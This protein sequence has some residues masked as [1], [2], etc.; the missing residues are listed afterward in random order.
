[1]TLFMKHIYDYL[2]E[3]AARNPQKTAISDE[4][5]ALTYAELN[6]KSSALA[7]RLE[8]MKINQGDAV[9]VYVPYVKE[10]ILG[11]FAAMRAG[12]AYLPLEYTYPDDRLS[13][14][15]KDS[16]ASAMLT[17]RTFWDERPLD[18]P[19]ERVIFMD[20][21]SDSALSI[22]ADIPMDAP[23]MILYTSGT[24]GRP[25]GV[26]LPHTMMVS[27][28]DW[29]FI[30]EGTK[31]TEDSRIGI[32]SG[33]TFSATTLI[34][35]SPFMYG[36][37]VLLAPEPVRKDM[38]LLH[39]FLRENSVTHTFLPAGLATTIVEH[40]DMSGINIFAGG[41]KL[42]NFHSVSPETRL[43]NTY[44]CTETGAVISA[45]IRGDEDV[46]PIGLLSPDTEAMIADDSLCPVP[47]GETGELLV[48]NARMARCYLGLPEQTNAKWIG[49]NGE[50]WYRTG[51]RA[52]QSADGL[53][54]ILGR[55]DNMI[56]IRGFRVETGEVETQIAGAAAKLGIT[57]RNSTVVVRTVNGIDHLTCYYESTEEADTRLIAEKISVSLASYM[58]PDIWVRMDAMP[59]NANGKIMRSQL[60]QPESYAS[61]PGMV[62]SEAEARVVEIAASVLGIRSYISPDDGFETLGG[63]SI[64]AMEF[65]SELRN[66]G[67]HISSSEV[68]K[69]NTLRE[70]AEKAEIQYERFWTQQEYEQIRADFAARGEH[71]EKVLPLTPEQDEALF[72]LLLHPDRQGSRHVFM[73]QVDS[74]ITAKELRRALDTVSDEFDQLRSSIVFHKVS[75][76]QQV[77]TDRTV[78]VQIIEYPEENLS[79]LK[80]LYNTLSRKY[81][82]LQQESSVQIVCVNMAKESFIFVLDYMAGINMSAARRYIARMMDVLSVFHP[83][84]ETIASWIDLFNMNISAVNEKKGTKRIHEVLTRTSEKQRQGTEAI[85]V[86]SDLPEKKKLIFVHTGN[87]GSEAY[88]SLAGRIRN[89]FSFAVLEPFNLYH[90]AEAKYGIRNIAARY[91]ETLKKFQPEG[92]YILGGWCYGGIVAHEMACQLQAMDEKIEYLFL[93]DS[94]VILDERVRKK[95]EAMHSSADREYFETADLFEDMR[96]HGMLDTLVENSRHVGYDMMTH[97]PSHYDGPCLYFK[98]KELPAAATGG[99]R[100]YWDLMKNEYAAGGYENYCSKELLTVLETPHEHDLMMDNDSLDII[101]PSI[102]QAILPDKG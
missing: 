73:F 59:R 87:T 98:P 31:L 55:T 91:V 25:K 58:V 2:A 70:I 38:D 33:L 16:S 69:L 26:I 57:L 92:P 71:I 29:A 40:Y 86:Y 83:E 51:D 88:Y 56:K 3:Y 90:P 46:I 42:R 21:I 47:S 66:A 80:E 65:V 85:H 39:T 52:R 7:L 23:A 64:K 22:S 19:S 102:Y 61:A 76:I 27:L 50:T 45:V 82:D 94:H 44:G 74:V 37:T 10:L 49:I 1:M 60:P 53:Y 62:F 93:L 78:P 100:E 43:I 81:A 11:T 77:I 99:A 68:L 84:D 67:I 48:R 79:G 96:L 12:G 30:H 32:M 75:V 15:L 101:V 72:E 35:Y 34:L 41:E 13:F 5:G 54:Y 63:T 24:T 97:A 8:Q 28:M 17:L 18:F 36:G 95:A 6:G 4:N 9:A 14:M 20:D 89:D